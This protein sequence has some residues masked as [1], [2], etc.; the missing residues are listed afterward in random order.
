MRSDRTNITEGRSRAA[1]EMM[2]DRQDGFR[3]DAEITFEQEIVNAHDR[4]SEGVFHRG[5]KSVRS[6]VRNGPES[7]IKGGT[8]NCSDPVAEKLDG[9]LL[10]ERAGFALE[11]HTRGLAVGSAHRQALS[12][13]KGRQ[14][15]SKHSPPNT[16]PPH[17]TN[18]AVNTSLPDPQ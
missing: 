1:N 7:G 12:C 17:R 3:D 9:S 15:K 5:Q 2:F 13:N 11:G 18:S 8:C 4:A 6:A 10:A 14:T 16:D